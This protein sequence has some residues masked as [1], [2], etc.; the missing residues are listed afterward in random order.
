MEIIEIFQMCWVQRLNT[1]HKKLEQQWNEKKLVKRRL[2]HVENG[3]FS[4]P[5]DLLEIRFFCV[6]PI[7][8]DLVSKGFYW[9]GHLIFSSFYFFLSY[10]SL[11]IFH[12]SRFLA[13][14]WAQRDPI[15]FSER[16]RSS[17]KYYFNSWNIKCPYLK[18]FQILE[19]EHK[20]D[21]LKK[22]FAI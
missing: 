15:F 22:L 14:P 10:F 9:S 2:E 12:H 5:E 6:L 1:T 7:S 21:E 20:Q 11:S 4:G 3:K 8:S 13:L 19:F 17:L 18:K 16:N